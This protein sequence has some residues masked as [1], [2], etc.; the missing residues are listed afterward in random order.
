[1]D[2]SELSPIIEMLMTDQKPKPSAA[3]VARVLIELAE[4]D[5]DVDQEPMAHMRLQKL[6]YYVQ[7]WSL[8]RRGE[9]AF[10]DRIEAWEHG[11]VVPVV[12]RQL[13]D[14]KKNPLAIAQL[15]AGQID[16]DLRAFIASVW[17]DYRSHSAI[18]LRGMTHDESPWKD[19]WAQ[20]F[21]PDHGQEEIT[22]AALS[23]Y[24]KSID[25]RGIR[26]FKRT[27]PSPEWF[28]EPSPFLAEGA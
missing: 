27:K 1:M 6:L 10:D 24:F 5:R 25:P 21:L 18:R 16:P 11:P 28:D 12:Y 15:E 23:E 22:E 9:K 7:G 14:N 19:A 2:N 20:R 4:Q 8:A 3:H 13:K 17:S 26:K